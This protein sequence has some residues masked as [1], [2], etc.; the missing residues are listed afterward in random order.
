MRTLLSMAIAWLALSLPG[1]VLADDTPD[2][3]SLHQQEIAMTRAALEAQAKIVIAKNLMLSD[4]EAPG[5]WQVYA[6]YRRAMTR[7]GDEEVA[8][9]QDYARAYRTNTLTDALARKLLE[10]SIKAQQQALKIKKSYIRKFNKVIPAR[11]V[12]RFYQIEHRIE[13][14]VDMQMAQGIP[15]VE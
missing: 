10:R 9:I 5:F 2:E 4:D 1:A 7:V 8:I 12:A 14:L 6:D 11:K 13:L 15:L 3:G